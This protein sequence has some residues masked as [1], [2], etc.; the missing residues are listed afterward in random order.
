MA[1]CNIFK[2]LTKETGTF[3][4]FSQYMED[5]T[6][7]QTESKYHRIVPSKFIAID[8]KQTNYTNIT[9]PKYI[10]EYFENACACFK[11]N[12]P[13]VV[14]DEVDSMALGWS[15]EYTKTL[16]WNMMFKKQESVE[17]GDLMETFERGLIDMEDIKYVSD[18]NL[19][20][21]NEVDSMGYSEI[22]CHIPNEASSYKY[23]V[24]KQEYSIMESISRKPGD[25]LEGFS[26]EELNGWEELSTVPAGFEYHYL[27]DNKYDFTWNDKKFGAVELKDKSF[28]IN[29]IVVLYDIWNDN[30][31]IFTEIPMG[32]YIT[33]LIDDN[34]NITNSIT[35]YVSNED[36]YNTGTSY[37]LRICSR[38]VVAPGEDRYIV[39]DVK[40]EDNNYNDL[41]R[42][43]S[44]LSISQ[45]KMDDVVNKTYNTEQNYKNLLAIFKNNRT[46]VPYIKI[47]NN[48]SCWFVNGKLIGPSVV[49]GVYD[50]YSND[51]IDY[52]MNSKLNQAFQIIATAR[53][54]K[55]RY[56]FE[57][58]TDP[59]IIL[60][61]DVYYEGKK[62]RPTSLWLEGGGL[63]QD[64]TGKNLLYINL[65]DSDDFILTAKYGKLECSTTTSVYFVNP[66][67]FGELDC[68]DAWTHKNN[69]EWGHEYENNENHDKEH[70]MYYDFDW[71][72]NN[73][74]LITN[75]L[76]KYLTNTSEHTY[77][78]STDPSNPG[79]ICYAYPADFGELAYIKDRDGYIYYDFDLDAGYKENQSSIENTF[80][81]IKDMVLKPYGDQDEVKYNVYISKVPTYVNNLQLI[82]KNR[83]NYIEV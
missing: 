6:L 1:V 61:W 45:N 8:C 16:F 74:S 75:T 49:D 58:F 33:G 66:T 24:R 54:E 5:L 4:T 82:F 39:K 65:T 12:L 62:I 41:S 34:L 64:V 40:V 47:V 48:E 30:T 83:L 25:K 52:L 68:R 21:Y 10:Q 79:H 11:N 56:I 78:V 2:K 76:P 31:P 44:Q 77:E 81:F 51:E 57:R 60:K 80:I 38:Y 26:Y 67:Y 59:Q 18:I 37:G 32:I 7:W 50:A 72:K 70:S 19:Q 29:M 53:D 55:D 28:N 46:N 14:E 15:P 63:S 43:L 23:D 35:K 36:I 69:T 17:E 20:S 27:L 73:P 42:V 71:I 13:P 3:L 9:L 22:Y